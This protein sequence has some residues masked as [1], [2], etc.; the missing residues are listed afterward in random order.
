MQLKLA[1]IDLRPTNYRSCSLLHEEITS[2][3]IA[4]AIHCKKFTVA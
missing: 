4:Y 2:S 3:M 1:A